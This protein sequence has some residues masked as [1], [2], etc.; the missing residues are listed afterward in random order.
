MRKLN[1]II[2]EDTVANREALKKILAQK[3]PQIFIV[4]EANNQD[5]AYELIK[6]ERPF[7]VFMDIQ[8][9]EGTSFDLLERLHKEGAVDFEIIFI[10]AFGKYE[11][12]TK[13]IEFSA[14]DFLTKPID[15]EKLVSAVEKAEKRIQ[16]QQH[17]EQI[18]LLLENLTRSSNRSKR[19]AFHLTKGIIEFVQVDEIIYLEADKTICTVFLKDGTKLTAMKNLGHYS[20][21]LI[22]DYDFFPISNSYLVNI[23]FVKRYNHSELTVKLTN[24]KYLYASRRGG[25]EFKKYLNDNKKEFGDLQNDGMLS[26]LKRLFGNG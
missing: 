1:T 16:N 22:A 3:C 25:Q 10:T 11:Y 6:S 9:R 17:N 4:G 20:K 8:M 21:L 23:N 12:A 15:S 14:L 18:T 24:D 7:L 19:I 26:F 2:L 13:A 5:E